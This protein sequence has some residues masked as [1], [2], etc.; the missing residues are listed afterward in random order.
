MRMI[1]IAFIILAILAALWMVVPLVHSSASEM[2]FPE[3][4]P[5][6]NI[7]TTTWEF[8]WPLSWIVWESM[9]NE[10]EN[11]DVS[12]PRFFD[13]IN[14]LVHL[15]AIGLPLFIA[16]RIRGGRPPAESGAQ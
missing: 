15:F 5:D 6:P 11:L 7:Y 3:G 4:A 13:S 1:R 2:G 8:G 9:R 10:A 16:V 14:L 12:K